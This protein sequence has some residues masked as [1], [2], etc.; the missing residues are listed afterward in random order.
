MAKQVGER[1]E[2]LE[3]PDCAAVFPLCHGMDV[4]IRSEGQSSAGGVQL[5]GWS[6]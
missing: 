3:W 5:K 2:C 6:G 1:G 4:I